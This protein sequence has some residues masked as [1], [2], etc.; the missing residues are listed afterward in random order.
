MKM[1]PTSAATNAS[2]RKCS[3]TAPNEVPTSTGA[4][5]AGSVRT[6]AAMSHTRTPPRTGAPRPGSGATGELGE[7]GLALLDV[8][9]TPLLGLLGHVEEEV[10]V[11]GQLLDARQAVLVGVEAG[12][13]QAQREGREGQHLPAPAHGLLL[14]PLQRDDRVHQPHRQG[15]LSV[16][17]TAQKPDL[18]RLLG[19]DQTAQHAGPEA[20]VE[21]PDLGAGL[22]EARVVGG[23]RE[24]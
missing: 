7:V 2:G 13:E 8:G 12:L 18:L 3:S 11:V 17:L 24:V 9:V 15:L 14:E 4:T 5:D 20:A 19:T 22:P 23:D 1:A 10:G 21:A 6:R 16:V